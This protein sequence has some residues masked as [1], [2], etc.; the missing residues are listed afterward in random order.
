MLPGCA[1]VVGSEAQAEQKCEGSV[2]KPRYEVIDREQLCWRPIDLE[3]LIGADHPARAMWEFIG[4]LDLSAYQEEVRAVEGQRAPRERQERLAQALK[5][6]AQL[7]KDKD[8]EER[9][10]STTDPEARVMK[11]PGGGYAPSYNRANR[12]RCKELCGGSGR[13]GPS[14]QRFRAIGPRDR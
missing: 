3:R 4:Q 10:V 2:G 1:A 12:H 8:N 9:R 5:E 6:F 7:E 14:G 13:S 11:Q